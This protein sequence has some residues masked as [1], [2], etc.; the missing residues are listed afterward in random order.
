MDA[1]EEDSPLFWKLKNIEPTYWDEYIATRPTYDDKIF[2]RIYDYQA[3][4][5]ESHSA[6]LDIGTGSG[7]AIG[8][9]TNRFKHVVASDND[10]TSLS[11]AK[12][13]Y[14]ALPAEHLSF[15]LSS[16]ED[17][18]QHHPPGS[19]DLITCAETF[20]LMDTQTAL[21]NISTLLRPGGTLA[22]WFYGPPYF[23]EA[24][25]GRT[26]QPILDTIMDHNFRPVVSGGGDARKG[27]WK[28][29]ADGMLSWLDYIPFAPEQWGNVRRHKWNTQAR[30]SFFTPQACDFSV[31]P[32]S[33]VLQ[34][35][36][37]SEEQDPGFWEVYWD[38]AMLRRF[39]TA[40]FPKPSELV[41]PDD[42]MDRLFEQLAMA[43]G[44]DKVARK[45]SWP[46]VLILAVKERL[47]E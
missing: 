16:G 31:E 20:P 42:K 41:G 3:N 4:H 9:L 15:S 35:E 23:T 22:V 37:V 33:N 45:L 5:S 47:H 8:P 2:Q 13:R 10:H 38:V 12:R 21:N 6:A 26:C 11:F 28:R 44:G 1:T 7:S 32:V 24:D 36:L 29:A 43:M 34:H 46:A 40:S 14:S 27:S 30:L 19:F 39:V 17:L 18:L 25:F